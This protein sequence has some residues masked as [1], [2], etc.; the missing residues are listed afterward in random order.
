[1]A[2]LWHRHWREQVHSFSWRRSMKRLYLTSARTILVRMSTRMGHLIL[3]ALPILKHSALKRVFLF[4]P[5]GWEVL[6]ALCSKNASGCLLARTRPV[7][8]TVFYVRALRVS[9]HLGVLA[10][11]PQGKHRATG[12]D[13]TTNIQRQ[14]NEY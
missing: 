8:N 9:Q 1:M 6:M 14:H 11:T 4:L 5:T 13:A 7:S 12:M 2:C 3:L 10:G